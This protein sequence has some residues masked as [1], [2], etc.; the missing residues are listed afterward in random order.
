MGSG[1]LLKLDIRYDAFS[2]HTNIL[3]NNT[4]MNPGELLPI[5]DVNNFTVSG[6]GNVGGDIC[7]L[8]LYGALVE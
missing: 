8:I 2:A 7:Y 6:Q 3:V 1:H 5:E 4:I